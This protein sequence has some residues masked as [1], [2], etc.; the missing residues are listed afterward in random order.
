MSK[1]LIVSLRASPR[2]L[3]SRLRGRCVDH[4]PKFRRAEMSESVA[5]LR[6]SRADD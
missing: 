3:L 6:A 5:R 4:A 1:R 2:H